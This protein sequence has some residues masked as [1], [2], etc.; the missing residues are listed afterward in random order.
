MRDSGGAVR[1]RWMMTL[2]TARILRFLT[3][4]N[5]KI[6]RAAASV[7]GDLT[8]VGP[9][10]MCCKGMVDQVSVS[11]R[12]YGFLRRT[13]RAALSLDLKT[14]ARRIGA[15]DPIID[16]ALSGAARLG[17]LARAGRTTLAEAGCA[18]PPTGD[19]RIAAQPGGPRLGA[20]G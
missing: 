3:G 18:A 2:D 20:G 17:G 10:V 7:F 15:A 1:R 9:D 5:P 14:M 19:P 12:T 13:I 4:D 6:R 8:M 11:K 16:L